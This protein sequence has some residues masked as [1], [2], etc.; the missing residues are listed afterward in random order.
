MSAIKR[1]EILARPIDYLPQNPANALLGSKMPM[2][3][4]IKPFSST[5]VPI[6]VFPPDLNAFPIIRQS[7]GAL[8]RS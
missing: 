5:N 2:N 8:K 7:E 6:A 4:S 3:V 1:D